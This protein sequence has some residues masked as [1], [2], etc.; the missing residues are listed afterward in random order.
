[1][2]CIKR[3][4]NSNVRRHTNI[5]MNEITTQFARPWS[6]KTPV[7]TRYMKKQHVDDFFEHGKLRISSFK[8]FRNNPDEEQGDFL[9]GRASA[10]IK[11][12]NG[13]HAIVAMNG[14]EAYVLCATTVESQKLE[15]SFSTEAG[16]RIISTLGFANCIS[17]H[18]PGFVAGL[19]GLCS[20][21]DDTAINK[22]LNAD[23]PPPDSFPNPE[24]WADE[25][26]KFVAQQSRDAFFIKR[27]KY[28]HQAEYR[29]IWFAQG[30]EKEY[31]DIICPEAGQFCQPLVSASAF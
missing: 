25:H 15:S 2:L 31:I 17:S 4:V 7:L 10:Q 21:R 11:T 29:F 16:F 22:K 8:S 18:I 13:N 27:S 3:P 26:D 24:I 9:E 14:Q 5:I 30:P 23:F 28:S 19:E 1:M 12:P 20:Y 6:I